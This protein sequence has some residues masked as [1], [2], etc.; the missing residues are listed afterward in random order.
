MS[1]ADDVKASPGGITHLLGPSGVIGLNPRDS[2]MA[3]T[4]RVNDV[5][6]GMGGI[7][8]YPAGTLGK[9]GGGGV[10]TVRFESV[11]RGRD[12]YTLG[13]YYGEE[14]GQSQLGTPGSKY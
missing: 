2:V 7:Q 1:F 3:T 10:G 11:T 8:S 14:F 13:T 12:I 9:G 4:N 5:Q 6:G